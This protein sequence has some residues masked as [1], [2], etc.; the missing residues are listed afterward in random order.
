MAT[1]GFTASRHVS[2]VVGEG[3]QCNSVLLSA[4]ASKQAEQNRA[5]DGGQGRRRE[6]GA[7]SLAA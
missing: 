7:A 6:S 4:C 5:R 1:A 2:V 3:K